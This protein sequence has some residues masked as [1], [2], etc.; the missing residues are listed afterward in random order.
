MTTNVKKGDSN[1]MNF[2]GK[3]ISTRDNIDI[4]QG[5]NSESE[6]LIYL[7]P[8]LNSHRNYAAPAGSQAAGAAFKDTWT[9]SDDE[10]LDRMPIPC[11]TCINQGNKNPSG[12]W[13]RCYYQTVMR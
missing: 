2:T 9:L 12:D 11:P 4:M 8:P 7:N 10:A 1:V 3:T 5:M 6:D 13:C